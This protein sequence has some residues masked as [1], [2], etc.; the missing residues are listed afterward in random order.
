MISVRNTQC[1]RTEI[2]YETSR[3]SYVRTF[4]GDKNKNATNADKLSTI[5]SEVYEVITENQ[6]YEP[7][8][9]WSSNDV[10]NSFD[11][12]DVITTGSTENIVKSRQQEDGQESVYYEPP[13]ESKEQAHIAEMKR[14]ESEMSNE[15]IY[16]NFGFERDLA[17]NNDENE[18]SYEVP[19]NCVC[20][21]DKEASVNS[22]T[23]TKVNKAATGE[24][25]ADKDGVSVVRMRNGSIVKF[26]EKTNSLKYE[27]IYANEKIV[28]DSGK[29]YCT[30]KYTYGLSVKDK[31]FEDNH[32]Y[33]IPKLSK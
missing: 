13:D 15:S 12:D 24:A 17:D 4:S 29:F 9:L 25:D 28:R 1:E 19:A 7:P 30:P 6:C 32:I 33:D 27:P 31:K 18:N 10:M 11:S 23:D 14:K 22:E 16:E 20:D 21:K 2:I 8:Q 3:K 5:S 26:D